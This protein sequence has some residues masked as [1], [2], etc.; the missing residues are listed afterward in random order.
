[1]RTKRLGVAIAAMLLGLQIGSVSTAAVSQS[2]LLAVES[3]VEAGQ[4]SELLAFLTANPDLLLLAG[5]LGDALR[6]FVEQPTTANLNQIA[7]LPDAAVAVAD[8]GAVAS[9]SIY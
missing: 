7:G 4:V 6:A 1:M 3:M 9:V 5:T 8:L 2:D